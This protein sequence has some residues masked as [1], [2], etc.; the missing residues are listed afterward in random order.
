MSWELTE[1]SWHYPFMI[2]LFIYIFFFAL[3]WLFY[4]FFNHYIF[5]AKLKKH[6]KIFKNLWTATT[7]NA[8]IGPIIDQQLNKANNPQIKD[9]YRAFSALA[10]APTVG[11]GLHAQKLKR[12]IDYFLDRRK[13]QIKGLAIALVFSMAGLMLMEINI[14]VTDIGIL[15]R[16]PTFSLITQ[17]LSQNFHSN[18]FYPL[19]FALLETF[20]AL[21]LINSVKK[22]RLWLDHE[23]ANL[24]KETL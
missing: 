10:A 20:L 11:G 3:F 17:W 9:L 1:I 2:K 21:W 13:L 5:F 7:S 16:T 12:E 18:L 23:W 22:L 8:E 6:I 14:L 4:Y 15:S 24:Q 19:A